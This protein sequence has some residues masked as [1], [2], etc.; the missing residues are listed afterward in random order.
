MHLMD[1]P[2]GK[3]SLYEYVGR[4]NYCG[5]IYHHKRCASLSYDKLLIK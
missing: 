4:G 1:L 2:I 5:L 3:H